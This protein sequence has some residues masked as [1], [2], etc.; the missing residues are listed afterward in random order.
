MLRQQSSD[1]KSYQLSH[2]GCDDKD[3]VYDQSFNDSLVSGY[4]D[5]AT[6]QHNVDTQG[7]ITAPAEDS[8]NMQH[9]K[10]I[11]EVETDSEMTTS[12]DNTGIDNDY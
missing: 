2:C 11:L 7:N 6:Y 10:E 3:T 4:T 12:E 1:S 5:N 9:N 8:T